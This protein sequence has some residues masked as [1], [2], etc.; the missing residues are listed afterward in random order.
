MG[1]IGDLGYCRPANGIGVSVHFKPKSDRARQ[2]PIKSASLGCPAISRPIAS[3]APRL[4]QD[5][6]WD[7]QL[8]SADVYPAACRNFT[9][10]LSHHSARSLSWMGAATTGTVISTGSAGQYE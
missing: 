4:R 2:G 9:D 5:S 10:D 8:S 7:R 6:S 1:R 3:C